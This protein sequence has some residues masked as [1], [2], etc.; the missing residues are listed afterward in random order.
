VAREHVQRRRR[1][2]LAEVRPQSACFGQ[3]PRQTLKVGTLFVS[4]L[5]D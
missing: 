2:R 1:S 3:A 5:V 4:L